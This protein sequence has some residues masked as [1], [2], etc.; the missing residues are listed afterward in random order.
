MATSQ[1][2]I[3]F[4]DPLGEP[5]AL[6]HWASDG[7]TPFGLGESAELANWIGRVIAGYSAIEFQMYQIYAVLADDHPK[8]SF[9]KFYKLRLINQKENLVCR[10]GLGLPDEYKSA[11]RRLWGRLRAA[12][13]RRSQVAHCSILKSNGKH[14]RLILM[15]E[16]AELAELNKQLFV[17]TVRQYRTLQTDAHIFLVYL[18][19]LDPKNYA[20]RLSE[21]PVPQ[22]NKNTAPAADPGP[23]PQRVEDERIASVKRLGL[24]LVKVI[25]NHS[26]FGRPN[27]R[28]VRIQGQLT[29][30]MN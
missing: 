2:P 4:D 10:S 22:G 19:F 20:R 24:S 7:R 29:V 27:Y 21:I 28:V 25:D 26:Y 16:R 12:A 14:L 8:A 3:S 23:L 6:W 11:L 9:T 15:G 1:E 5:D 18:G 30:W 17:R 13:D